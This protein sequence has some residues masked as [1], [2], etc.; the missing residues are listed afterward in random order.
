[1]SEANFPIDELRALADAACDGGLDDRLAVRL[2][3]LL[4]GNS[5]AQRFYLS[6]VLLDGCLRWEFG[7]QS[8]NQLLPDDAERFEPCGALPNIPRS[9]IIIDLDTVGGHRPQPAREPFVGSPLFACMVA[10]VVLAVMLLGAWLYKISIP[11][12]PA[13]EQSHS[14]ATLDVPL[15]AIVG[16]VTGLHACRWADADTE[17]FR[18]ALVRL[19]SKYSL[20]AGLLEITYSTGARVILEGPCEYVIDSRA[21]GYLGVGK[22]IARVEAKSGESGNRGIGESVNRENYPKRFYIPRSPLRRPHAVGYRYRPR[23]EVWRH[24]RRRRRHGN[25]CDRR[26]R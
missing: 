10:T 21:S 5:A 17:T 24:C 23:H 25:A 16:R 7:A 4:R 6:H 1:M 3:T 19:D 20:D 8:H 22:L 13:V 26:P 9:S 2:E 11:E 12:P 14:I 18:G 15:P